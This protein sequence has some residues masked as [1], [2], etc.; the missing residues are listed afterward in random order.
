MDV[1]LARRIVAGASAGRDAGRWAGDRGHPAKS[2]EPDHGFPWAWDEEV[3]GGA[4]HPPVRQSA[5]L[6]V[7][8]PVAADEFAEA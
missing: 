4:A 2:L 3:A 5:R 6:A 7:A 1:R 8:S